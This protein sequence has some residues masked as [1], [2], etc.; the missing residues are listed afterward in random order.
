M[1]VM[2]ESWIKIHRSLLEWEW[3]DD[4]PTKTVWLHLL[5][6]ANWEDKKYHGETIKAGEAVIGRKAMA[7]QLGLSE[8]SIRTALK[9]LEETG[10]ISVR[11]TNKYSVVT[12]NNW[13]KFQCCGQAT[14]NQP[15][16]ALDTQ[17]LS[18]DDD[19]TANQ[20]V[21][22]EQPTTNQQLTTPKEIKNKENINIVLKAW[23]D[24]C[25]D[26]PKV[27]KADAGST[28]AKAIT[29]RVKEYGLDKV[30]EVFNKVQASKF[31]RG[32]SD[33]GW[34]A[35]FDWVVKASNFQ[36]VMEGNYDD[37]KNNKHNTER[38]KAEGDWD[39]ILL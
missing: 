37:R 39:S 8:Q 20:Q 33:S 3:Y 38:N 29:A 34:K 23:N 10:E 5:L 2:N 6:I 12:V 32:E 4:I 31:L 1:A 24:T 19:T 26:Y 28:R 36:K 22:N 35:T 14:N 16:E 18:A 13:V 27:L 11:A 15:A 9:H 7:D 17:G 30:Q 21:T 25:K